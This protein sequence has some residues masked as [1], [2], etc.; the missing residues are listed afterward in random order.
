MNWSAVAGRRVQ[1]WS[2]RLMVRQGQKPTHAASPARSS[3]GRPTDGFSSFRLR[4]RG[5][6]EDREFLDRPI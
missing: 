1:G 3:I 2:G 5:V 4:Q 6:G